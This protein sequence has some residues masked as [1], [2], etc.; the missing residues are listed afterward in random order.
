MTVEQCE[1][2]K[3]HLKYEDKQCYPNY[4]TKYCRECR[5]LS[6]SDLSYMDCH[7]FE[8]KVEGKQCLL[9]ATT[10]YKCEVKSCEELDIEHCSYFVTEDKSKKCTYDSV[11]NKCR[12]KSC[13]EYLKTDCYIFGSY[14]N[15]ERECVPDPN[16]EYCM[17]K[18]CEDLPVKDCT[19]FESNK[20]IQCIPQDGMCKGVKECDELTSN[21]E[22][23]NV[24]P[25][26]KCILN[27]KTNKCEI[28]YKQCEELEYYFCPD[29]LGEEPE[30]M[31]DR[32]DDESGCEFKQCS[33][34]SYCPHFHSKDDSLS[35]ERKSDMEDVCELKNC[36][37]YNVTECHKFPDHYSSYYPQYQCLPNDANTSCEIKYCRDF[38][39][40][41]C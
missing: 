31:C 10:S 33:D 39:I 35:C 17:F 9:S 37:N 27:E 41:E 12:I 3:Y 8:T 22:S 19:F 38:K 20:G 15:E 16:S 32:K 23:F 18:K 4:Q 5:E 26:E 11:E 14:F 2:Q 6:C 29:Y 34:F 25:L 13:E 7:A 24:G 21:C 36:S 1:N 30:F 40:D 28:T